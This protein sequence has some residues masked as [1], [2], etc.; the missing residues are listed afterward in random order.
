MERRVYE[1][2]EGHCKTLGKVLVAIFGKLDLSKVAQ[3]ADHPLVKI[4]RVLF[5]PRLDAQHDQQSHLLLVTLSIGLLVQDISWDVVA[6][7][8]FVKQLFWTCK[9]TVR[10]QEDLSELQQLDTFFFFFFRSFSDKG[11]KRD[12]QSERAIYLASLR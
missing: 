5:S 6:L 4:A 9:R 12:R 1:F 2:V 3:L 10:P 11:N 7:H 8:E